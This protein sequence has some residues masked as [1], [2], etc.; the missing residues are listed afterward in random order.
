MTTP[1][2]QS[3]Q[4]QIA[5]QTEAFIQ[6]FGA[7]TPEQLNWKPK[8]NDWSVGQVID[9]II[10]VNT[11]YFHIPEQIRAGTYKY[12]FVAKLGFFPKMMGNMIYK[13]VL[14]ETKRKQA[15]LNIWEPAQSDISPDILQQF[16]VHQHEFSQFIA[17]NQDFVEKGTLVCSPANKLIVYSW[18]RAFEIMLAHEERHFQQAMVVME[19]GGKN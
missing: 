13:S 6:A 3:F 17:D 1:Q 9:H 15:T 7:L 12:P 5:S 2:I 19:A 10:V 16:E 11:S 4:S 18:E 14:P 8:A